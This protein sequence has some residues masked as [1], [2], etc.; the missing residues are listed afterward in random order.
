[1][2][3]PLPEPL[4]TAELNPEPKSL[5]RLLELSFSLVVR[6]GAFVFMC[7][8]EGTTREAAFVKSAAI[9]ADSSSS[10]LFFANTS[11]GCSI[12]ETII[13]LGPINFMYIAAIVVAQTKLII[14]TKRVCVSFISVYWG[15]LLS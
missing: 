13:C 11:T 9:G 5:N 12:E 1:M 8:T 7:T 6:E 4:R 14:I 3:A 10:L 15:V 2:M